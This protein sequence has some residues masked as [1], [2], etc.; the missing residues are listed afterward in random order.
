MPRFIDLF[1][2]AGGLS[3]GFIRAGFEP[4]AHIEMDKFACDTLRTRAAFHYLKDNN[5]L[6]IY[7]NYLLNK[8]E[9]EDGK[10][11]WKTV[12]PEVI[13]SVI[14]AEIGENTI[15]DIFSVVDGI[16]GDEPIDIIIGGPPCQA[17]SVAG[18]ARLGKKIELDPRNDLYKFYVQF[19]ERYNPKIFVFENVPSIRTAKS[20]EPYRDLQRLVKELGY[21]IKG[22]IQLASDFGV[23]QKRQRMI[24]IG[25]K[26]LDDNGN[27][28]NYHYPDFKKQ[29]NP[30]KT[31]KDLFSDLPILKAGEGTLCGRTD[32][33]KDISQMDYLQR[34]NL[35]G[36]IPFTTQHIARPNNLNDREIYVWAIKKYLKEKKQ[37]SY[38]EIP[39]DHQKHKNKETFLNRFSVVNPDGC[40]HTVVAHIAMDG[41]YYIY[42][43]PNPTIDSVRSI[44]VREAARLQSFPDDYFFEGTRSAAFKQIG[45]A[46]PILLAEKIAEKIAEQL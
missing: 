36:V 19:L 16:V 2:G 31:M 34:N 32:Y 18:R 20:G 25:W 30:Y 29:D 4:V 7:E 11:L 33:T 14:Q 28:T 42:P 37:L 9:K 38:S 17:Y 24:I 21:D 27:P 3:E 46:V 8:K 12:P 26:I 35:R 44:S 39:A 5:Q 45:N 1:A 23:L 22:E 40:C 10:K 43:T 15:N 6:S 41:H 13:N